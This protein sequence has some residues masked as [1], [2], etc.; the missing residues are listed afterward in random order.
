MS[1]EKDCGRLM[2]SDSGRWQS[3]TE[4]LSELDI[5]NANV[6]VAVAISLSIGRCARSSPVVA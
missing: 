6:S 5:A 3:A 4:K 1:T 2:T